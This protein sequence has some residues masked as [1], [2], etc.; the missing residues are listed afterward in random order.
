MERW[1]NGTSKGTCHKMN[2]CKAS[3][4][5]SW[6]FTVDIIEDKFASHYVRSFNAREVNAIL[7]ERHQL[8]AG[9]CHPRVMGWS[10][11]VK[12]MDIDKGHYKHRG[13]DMCIWMFPKIVVPEI[14]NFNR[15][16]HYKPSI[17][18]YPYCWKHPYVYCIAIGFWISV[19]VLCSWILG[20]KSASAE[21]LAFSRH[22]LAPATIGCWHWIECI[23]SLLGPNIW[24]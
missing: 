15:V 1:G 21:D 6:S 12:E 5:M 9:T 7:L 16:F 18:G 3:K 14:I 19:G 23:F 17:L 22:A 13:S 24:P 2:R 20:S 8:T 10:G 4:K 11:E